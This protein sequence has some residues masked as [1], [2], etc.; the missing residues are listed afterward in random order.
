M[1]K[2]LA[3]NRTAAFILTAFLIIL[4]MGSLAYLFIRRSGGSPDG[5]IIRIYRDSVLI[6]EIPFDAIKE[7]RRVRY[8][9]PDGG[10]NIVSFSPE[11][12][13]I[14]EASCPDKTCIHIGRIRDS[15]LPLVCLPNRLVIT[16]SDPEEDST[17]PDAVSY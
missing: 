4:C 7:E 2:E 15:S 10:Y 17:A 6:E 12:V 11:G 3:Q 8:S 14:T 9:T 13:S 1:K 16:I 5:Q